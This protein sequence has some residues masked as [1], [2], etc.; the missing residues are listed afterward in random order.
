MGCSNDFS[1]L[2]H[3]GIFNAYIEPKDSLSNIHTLYFLLI[4]YTYKALWQEHLFYIQTSSRILEKENT[5]YPWKLH[6]TNFL[7]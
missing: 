1:Y 3:P 4:K 5:F 6:E 7:G 2:G